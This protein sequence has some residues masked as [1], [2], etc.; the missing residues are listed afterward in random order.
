M[1]SS[2]VGWSAVPGVERIRAAGVVL[3]RRDGP[4]PEALAPVNG[5]PMNVTRRAKPSEFI[6][7]GVSAID[8]MNAVEQ[9]LRS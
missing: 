7:T 9:A 3:L 1:R 6:E 8:G 5:A 4:V 2:G